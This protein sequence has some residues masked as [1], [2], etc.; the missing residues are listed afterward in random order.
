MRELAGYLCRRACSLEDP[1]GLLVGATIGGLEHVVDDAL[2]Y[3]HRVR[4]VIE[5]AGLSQAQ[6]QIAAKLFGRRSKGDVPGKLVI[7]VV[8]QRADE[9]PRVGLAECRPRGF[10]LDVPDVEG[11]RRPPKRAVC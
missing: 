9:R 5:L 4:R 8:E 7:T 11:L 2:V 6:P 10:A 1:P 3:G